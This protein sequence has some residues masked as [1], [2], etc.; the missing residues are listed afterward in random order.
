MPTAPL[1]RSNQQFSM[2][3]RAR[4]ASLLLV[5]N[6]A[7]GRND[8]GALND[9]GAAGESNV[10]P[11]PLARVRWLTVETFPSSASTQ[12]LLQLVDLQKPDWSGVSVESTSVVNPL[13]SSD[14]RWV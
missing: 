8:G 3:L 9:G 2:S 1:L 5:L 11:G 4:R 7:G 6:D 12:S 10:D 14:Q 13:P